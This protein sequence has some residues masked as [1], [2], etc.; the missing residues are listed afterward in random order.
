V[1]TRTLGIAGLADGIYLDPDRLIAQFGRVRFRGGRGLQRGF[2]GSEV[3]G[4]LCCLL[5]G[6]QS[7]Q[8]LVFF[9]PQKRGHWLAPPLDY[10]AFAPVA[11]ACEQV[12]RFAVEI[13]SRN[14]SG[15]HDLLKYT[16]V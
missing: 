5:P 14:D 4:S 9:D 8:T 6:R 7:F 12:T 10:E 16:V 1:S 3:A 11:D 13:Y 15:H 2:E